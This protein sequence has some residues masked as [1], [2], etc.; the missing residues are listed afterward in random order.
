M[1]GSADLRSRAR[2]QGKR[3]T[4]QRQLIL[5]AIRVAGGHVTPNEIFRRV[6]AKS[7][8]MNRTTVYRNLDFLCEMRLVVAAQIS[9]KMQYEIAGVRP[10]HHLVCRNCDSV[11][12]IS[13]QTV[14]ALFDK[15]EREQSFLIDMDHLAL[16]GLCKKCREADSKAQSKSKRRRSG[17]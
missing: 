7:P 11:E 13:H 17:S 10:H 12:E 8:A 16:F 14:K 4:P 9:G 6:S 3:V 15:I 5:D 2:A 1:S